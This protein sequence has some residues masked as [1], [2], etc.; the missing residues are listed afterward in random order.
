[1]GIF[2]TIA[3]ALK[4]IPGVATIFGFFDKW[5][6]KTPEEKERKRLK[7]VTWARKESAYESGAAMKKAEEGD[8]SGIE[9]VLN[10]K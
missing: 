9:D 4:A 3:A 1:M 8:T 2:T 10:G 6:G 7:E 5:F